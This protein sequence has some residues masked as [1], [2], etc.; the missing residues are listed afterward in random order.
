MCGTMQDVVIAVYYMQFLY[1]CILIYHNMVGKLQFINSLL[2]FVLVSGKYAVAM[3][4]IFKKNQINVHVECM[5]Y[6]LL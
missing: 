6:M 1:N 3:T 4:L 5:W 2:C